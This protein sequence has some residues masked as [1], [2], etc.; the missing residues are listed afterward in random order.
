MYRRALLSL[1]F[2]TLFVGCAPSLSPLY[3]DYD[4]EP[5]PASTSDGA[6][7]R[8]AEE[9]SGDIYD[10]IRAALTD[11]GWTETPSA[12]PNAI[13]TEPRELSNWGIYRVVVSLDAVPVGE[14]HVRVLFHPARVYF[15]G[16][17]SKIPY[18][19][20]GL[21]RALLP[22]LNEAFEAQGLYPIGTPR[23]RDEEQVAGT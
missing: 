20:S 11:A 18:L 2:A 23:E 3:R 21:R 7:E 17:R 16:G 5:A 15:T 1:C 4:V 8:P 9:V 19:G 22:D 10:R 6:S 14:Q 12:A 13:S